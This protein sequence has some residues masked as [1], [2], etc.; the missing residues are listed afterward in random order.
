MQHIDLVKQSFIIPYNMFQLSRSA[1][2]R[3]MSD[4]QKEGKVI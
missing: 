4:T 3:Q 2:I 1:I